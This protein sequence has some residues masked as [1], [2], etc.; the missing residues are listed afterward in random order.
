MQLQVLCTLAE[1]QES[2]GL[3]VKAQTPDG[4]CEL[5]LFRV[6]DG[7]RAWLN[8]CPHM[9]RNLDFAP[10]EFLLTPRGELVCPHHGA[11]FELDSGRCVEG[12]CRG[13]A[14]TAVEVEIREGK[15]FETG[16]KKLAGGQFPP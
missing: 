14:L 9:G 10:G 6:G 1:L 3:A 4:P 15:V 12:P 5:V 7:V 16:P 13:D 2:G 11:C 8:V